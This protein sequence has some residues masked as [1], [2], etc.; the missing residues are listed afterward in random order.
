M[1]TLLSSPLVIPHTDV[2]LRVMH[3]ARACGPWLA[4]LPESCGD[5]CLGRG[6]VALRG[7]AVM[8]A[9]YDSA[10]LEAIRQRL[11]RRIADAAQSHLHSTA[12][13]YADKLVAL[14]GEGE[15]LRSGAN[16]RSLSHVFGFDSV[17]VAFRLCFWIVQ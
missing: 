1:D 17:E 4:G 12:I 10:T 2:G 14:A 13:F 15:V 16:L 5:P 9:T 7:P 8:G 3:T 11:R 6:R